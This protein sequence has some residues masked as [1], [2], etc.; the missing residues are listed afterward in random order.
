MPAPARAASVRPGGVR[1]APRPRPVR[2]HRRHPGQVR[3]DQGGRA[4]HA[5]GRAPVCGSRPATV[6]GRLGPPGLPAGGA[7]AG[8]GVGR[9]RR[10]SRRRPALHVQRRWRRRAA[11]PRRRPRTAGDVGVA[12]P[13]APRHR[14]L[15]AHLEPA[16]GRPRGRHAVCGR[17]AC[18]AVRGRFSRGVRGRARGPGPTC[19]CARSIA[20]SSTRSHA[21]LSFLF[22]LRS[23]QL[24]LPCGSPVRLQLGVATGAVCDGLVGKGSTLDYR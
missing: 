2:G 9:A 18:C 17:Y 7:A 10:T 5:G 13:S 16:R 4:A 21:A 6:G 3:P 22:S 14:L 24:T 20:V 11:R 23:T 12:C 19:F 8:R 15:S 1:P